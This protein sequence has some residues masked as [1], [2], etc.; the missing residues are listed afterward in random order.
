MNFSIAAAIASLTFAAALATQPASKPAF[1]LSDSPP[2]IAPTEMTILM[3]PNLPVIKA[4]G[5]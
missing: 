4:D 3:K 2:S 1:V 5:F